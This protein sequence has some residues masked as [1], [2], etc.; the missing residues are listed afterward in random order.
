MAA[1]LARVTRRNLL[2]AVDTD[3]DLVALILKPVDP[4]AQSQPSNAKPLSCERRF[5]PSMMSEFAAAPRLQQP[6]RWRVRT[7]EFVVSHPAED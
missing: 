7:R 5:Q 2:L 6:V 3:L 4:A 1:T